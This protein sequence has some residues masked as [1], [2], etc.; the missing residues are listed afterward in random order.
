[1]PWNET[2]VANFL[3]IHLSM[4][5]YFQAGGYGAFADYNTT[6]LSYNTSSLALEFE[7]EKCFLVDGVPFCNEQVYGTPEMTI[8]PFSSDLA[9]NFPIGVAVCDRSFGRWNHAIYDPQFSSL[10]LTPPDSPAVAPNSPTAKSNRVVQIVV[11]VVVCV[12][13]AAVVVFIILVFNVPAL[14]ARFTPGRLSS[15]EAEEAASGK[16]SRSKHSSGASTHS[17]APPATTQASSVVAT[18]AAAPAAVQPTRTTTGGWTKS[19]KPANE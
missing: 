16:K 2:L 7:F 1:M 15:L 14:K 5:V 10:F 17:Y 4:L 9:L 6:T 3:S 8:G 19:A 11:P 13:V 18:P 12:I